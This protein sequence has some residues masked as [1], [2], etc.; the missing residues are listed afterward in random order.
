MKPEQSKTT[1]LQVIQGGRPSLADIARQAAQAK[2]QEREAAK[3]A[4]QERVQ[5]LLQNIQAI[6]TE[7]AEA[8]E[9]VSKAKPEDRAAIEAALEEPRKEREKEK[10]NLLRDPGVQIVHIN[11]LV[12]ELKNCKRWDKLNEIVEAAHSRGWFLELI[13]NEK[14]NINFRALK[15]PNFKNPDLKQA[16]S[17]LKNA[18]FSAIEQLVKKQADFNAKKRSQAEGFTNKPRL[19]KE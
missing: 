5:D 16:C 3:Q 8:V 10:A 1:E 12:N 7:I 19:T 15:I 17:E 9:L 14:G 13:I 6:N 11:G 18:V 4:E 2:E